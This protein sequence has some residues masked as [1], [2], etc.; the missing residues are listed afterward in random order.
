MRGRRSQNG[1]SCLTGFAG[2]APRFSA[3]REAQNA[4]ADPPGPAFA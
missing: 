1:K 4:K 3:S 2:H